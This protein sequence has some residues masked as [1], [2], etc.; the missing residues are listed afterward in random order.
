M[1]A[2]M[3]KLQDVIQ[4]YNDMSPRSIVEAAVVQLGNSEF[5]VS[6]LA[7]ENFSGI[8]HASCQTSKVLLAEEEG[9]TASEAVNALHAKVVARME[10]W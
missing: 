5:R 2:N 6:I 3:E 7:Y 4:F 9:K 1:E 10:N 8:L